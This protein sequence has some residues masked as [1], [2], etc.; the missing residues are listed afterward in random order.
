MKKILKSNLFKISFLFCLTFGIFMAMILLCA[1][2]LRYPVKWWTAAKASAII[3]A[4]MVAMR[5]SGKKKRDYEDIEHGSTK[6]GTKKES[7]GLIDKDFFKNIILSATVFLSMNM[8]KTRKNCHVF[9]VGGSGAGK[10]KF[11]ALPNIMQMNASY[12][13]TDP[14]GDHLSNLG[15]MLELNSY[16]VKVFNVVNMAA[17]MH[18]NPFAY[19]KSTEDILRFINILIA[20]TSGGGNQ[21]KSDGDFWGNAEKLWF[22]AHISYITETCQEEEQNL[23]S[24]VLLLNNSETREE[25]EGFKSAIDVLFDD[26]G[27][28][29]QESFA[30]KQYKKYKLAAGKTAK[31]ILISVG[32]R[33]AYFDIPAL[34]KLVEDDELELE[35]MGDAKTALFIVVNDHDPTYNFLVTI[36]L[37]VLFNTLADTADQQPSHHLQIPVRCILDEI[38]NIGFF[39]NLHILIAVLRRRWVSLEFLFQNLNQLKAQYKDNWATIEG[40]C[41]TTVFLGGKGEDTTKYVSNDL[42]GKAT[43]DTVSYGSSGTAC[44]LGNNGY[45]SNDQK[46]GRNLLDETEVSRLEDDECIVSI[47][48][49]NPFFCKKYIP[50]DHP[51]YQLTADY[52][53]ENTYRFHRGIN[54]ENAD[55]RYVTL[56]LEEI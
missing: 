54:I 14:S 42:L 2:K 38:A 56:D 3:S 1:W 19:F 48:G 44:S 36:L 8:F 11:Y 40:N 35:A 53:S 4:L 23:N 18:F 22:M 27:A 29:N 30:V 43:I 49:L 21:N 47:R 28:K 12:V 5:F 50:Q 24:L 33:L 32:V 31:S 10:S 25:D 46:A 37:D 6:W 17:S 9:V 51:N 55:I 41:D 39:P 26:L 45:S 7:K 52:N 15:K 13:I 20:N 34:S 16:K